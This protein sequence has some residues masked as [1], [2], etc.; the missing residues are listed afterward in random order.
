M[1]RKFIA[2][3]LQVG[4]IVLV[5]AGRA[6]AQTTSG[7]ITGTITDSTGAVIPGAHVQLANQATGI[8]RSAVTDADGYYTVPELQPGVYDVTVNKEGVCRPKLAN[9]HLEVN[10]SGSLELQDGSLSV[11]TDSSGQCRYSAN[12]Y[13]LCD[14]GRSGGPHRDRRTAAERPSV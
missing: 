1:S 6:H 10:Q 7:L 2:L 9:V 11:H 12:Q 5:F 14:A 4:V 8:Q 3:A 13:N